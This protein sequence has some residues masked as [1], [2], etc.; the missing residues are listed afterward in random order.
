VAL[1][2]REELARLRVPPRPAP[3]RPPRSRSLSLYLSISL[4]LYLSSSLPLFLSSSLPLFLSS[5]P[6]LPFPPPLL[7][8]SPFPPSL[9]VPHPPRHAP[10]LTPRPA[11]RPAAPQRPRWTCWASGSPS[12]PWCTTPGSS[13]QSRSPRGGP[14][15]KIRIPVRLRVPRRA[16]RTAGR[17]ALTSGAPAGVLGA[18]GRRPRLLRRRDAAGRAGPAAGPTLRKPSPRTPQSAGVTGAPPFCAVLWGRPRVGALAGLG[19]LP[20]ARR[21]APAL[22]R[23][24]RGRVGRALLRSALYKPRPAPRPPPLPFPALTG[25]VS[26]LPSY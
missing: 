26:S 23:T 14:E 25:Q 15:K 17:A 7:S 10:R 6:S 9:P 21:A 2:G 8:A 1:L 18:R 3:R 24:A 22:V 11:R 4:S 5:S 19:A 12:A 13:P 16:R 20:G